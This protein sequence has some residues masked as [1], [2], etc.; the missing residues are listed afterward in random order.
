M[1]RVFSAVGFA[2]LVGSVWAGSPGWRGCRAE[3]APDKVVDWT[4]ALPE[5]AQGVFVNEDGDVFCTGRGY[6]G[7]IVP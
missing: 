5:K 1:K 7:D 2:L 3:G 6:K 4:T